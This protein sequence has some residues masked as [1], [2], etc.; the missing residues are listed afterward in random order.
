[1]LW[2]R[3]MN[4]AGAGIGG[5]RKGR[6]LLLVLC[7]FSVFTGMGRGGLAPLLLLLPSASNLSPVCGSSP[8]CVWA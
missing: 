8:G 1:M 6:S 4:D 5:R 2:H 3:T 7:F